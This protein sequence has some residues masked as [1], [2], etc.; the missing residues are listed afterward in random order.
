MRY[1]LFFRTA[2]I[3]NNTIY[4][5][6]NMYINEGMTIYTNL[7]NSSYLP[8]NVRKLIRQGSLKL[9]SEQLIKAMP[10]TD[11]A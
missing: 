2:V 10:K 4:P 8:C 3:V 6:Y 5:V 1:L 7:Y 11:M 9:K